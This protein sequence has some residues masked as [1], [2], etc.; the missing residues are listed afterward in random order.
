MMAAS[1]LLLGARLSTVAL[2]GLV[3]V[4]VLIQERSIHLSKGVHLKDVLQTFRLKNLPVAVM[5]TLCT[6][7]MDYAYANVIRV[8]MGCYARK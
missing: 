5:V 3:N 1:V 6:T 4:Y 7:H 8:S 2:M